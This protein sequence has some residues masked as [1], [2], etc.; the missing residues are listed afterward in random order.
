MEGCC[1][2]TAFD[3]FGHFCYFSALVASFPQVSI[4]NR[5]RCVI[6]HENLNEM[7][8]CFLNL[9]IGHSCVPC[10]FIIFGATFGFYS[11]LQ[12]FL[13]YFIT[14]LFILRSIFLSVISV[15][16]QI[17]YGFLADILSMLA[18]NLSLLSLLYLLLVHYNL[19]VVVHHSTFPM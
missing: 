6:L 1:G 4:F 12:C 19:S 11:L 13:I 10:A 9:S 16:M 18:F 3:C 5:V 2:D 7:L 17:I 14:L 15:L 8:F